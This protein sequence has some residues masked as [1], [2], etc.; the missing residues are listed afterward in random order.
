MSEWQDREWADREW[1][2][3]GQGSSSGVIAHPCLALEAGRAL[4][5]NTFL[6]LFPH[7]N[8][9]D[10]RESTEVLPYT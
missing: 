3:A 8:T 5:H 9:T 1:A 10:G 7:L 6:P 4:V 2:G